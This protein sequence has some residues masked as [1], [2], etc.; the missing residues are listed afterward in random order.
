MEKARAM[1]PMRYMEAANAEITLKV[2]R[3]M[4]HIMGATP[5]DRTK[6]GR[7]YWERKQRLIRRYGK[8]TI[9]ATPSMDPKIMEFQDRRTRFPSMIFTSQNPEFFEEGKVKAEPKE[10][11]MKTIW[12]L[13]ERQQRAADKGEDVP[14]SVYRSAR[15]KFWANKFKGIDQYYGDIRKEENK[16]LEKYGLSGEPHE[17]TP[18]IVHFY[19]REL[20]HLRTIANLEAMKGR[21][22]NERLSGADMMALGSFA[23]KNKLAEDIRKIDHR[24]LL[25]RS[26]AFKLGQLEQNRI[27]I[28]EAAGILGGELKRLHDTG[29]FPEDKLAEIWEKQKYWGDKKKRDMLWEMKKL[30]HEHEP[31]FKPEAIERQLKGKDKKAKEHVRAM[32]GAKKFK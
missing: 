27:N 11:H 13:V 19:K 15:Q 25:G 12:S 23:E 22:R 4:H 31:G 6:E 10:E 30:G 9:D 24:E 1:V 28:R 14:K 17:N 16:V 29:Y 2:G 21:L 5:N 26:V 8:K 32:G 3:E 18:L 7:M 20:G